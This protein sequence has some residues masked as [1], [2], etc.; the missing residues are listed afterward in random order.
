VFALPTPFFID[1]E[2]VIRE[3][4]SGPVDERGAGALIESMLAEARPS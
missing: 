2:G 4:V 1:A 3:V